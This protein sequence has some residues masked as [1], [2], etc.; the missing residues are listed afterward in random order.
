MVDIY[1]ALGLFSQ[2]KILFVDSPDVAPGLKQKVAAILEANGVASLD[3]KRL[4]DAS[5]YAD[6]NDL[7]HIIA[8]T[9]DFPEFAV[10]NY[11]ML[12]II[13]PQYVLVSYAE[14]RLVPIRAHSPDPRLFLKEVFL[15]CTTSIP[16][17]DV[18]A[19]YG[20]VRAVGGQFMDDLTKF[21]THL[22]TMDLNDD[23][24]LVAQA[25]NLEQVQ[26]GLP[27]PIQI[28]LPHWIDDCLKSMK[29]ID[30][31]PYVLPAA[32]TALLPK[33]EAP[34]P[35]ETPTIPSLYGKHVYLSPSLNLSPR[36][37]DTIILMIRSVGGETLSLG[38]I[39]L[40]LTDVLITNQRSSEDFRLAVQHNKTH[41]AILIANFQWLQRT[42]GTQNADLPTTSLV[43]YPEPYFRGAQPF[44][45][46]V[47]TVTNYTGDTRPYLASL[48]TMLG[49][50]F[51]KTLKQTN[52]HL[53]AYHGIQSKKFEAA[54]KW[55]VK[56]VNHLWI[57]DCFR[58]L[59]RLDEAGE[60]YHT[61]YKIASGEEIGSARVDLELVESFAMADSGT[62]E[63]VVKEPATPA[64]EIVIVSPP[65]TSRRA[66]L[67]AVEQLH[68]DMDDL[69]FYQKQTK[70]R[71]MPLLREEVEEK[72][73]QQ[74]MK[75]E[76]KRTRSDETVSVKKLKT[77]EH[78]V[79]NPESGKIESD[80]IESDKI[81]SDK[82]ESGKKGKKTTVLETTLEPKAKG[83]TVD[84]S[85]KSKAR[86]QKSATPEPSTPFDITLIAT[87]MDF[88]ITRQQQQQL[89]RIG[90]KVVKTV[91]HADVIVSPKILRTE[92]FLR[93]L[94][95]GLKYVLHPSFIEDV[96][97][98]YVDNDEPKVPFPIEKYSLDV[99]TP[100][101]VAEFLGDISLS[102]L[103][104]RARK[105]QES[106][107]LFHDVVL[108]FSKNLPGGANV[109][110]GVM[111]DHGCSTANCIKVATLK[112]L[113]HLKRAETTDLVAY[114]LCAATKKEDTKLVESFGRLME[115]EGTLGVVVQWNW[116]VL[117]IFHMELLPFSE[118]TI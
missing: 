58:Q 17:D 97:E 12:P 42:I 76:A 23:K 45:G 50:K 79:E 31:Q 62:F 16:R 44:Q 72:L 52:T 91:A 10:A 108:N 41:P 1:K 102:E 4:D 18:L 66:K 21:T 87:G 27:P 9:V 43:Y 96:I 88:E 117:S 107:G 7:T 101:A 99:K 40:D 53:V 20:A 36:E 35:S 14:E 68:S 110:S 83:K 6:L 57:E 98:Y 30:E 115:S 100:E 60:R 47:I 94:A 103:L 93:G 56:I 105:C 64:K 13:T 38:P 74:Q 26:N 39:P 82:I 73:Q 90:V 81:K 69:N 67:K 24:S 75:A 113:K 109:I 37:L 46:L 55:G 118:Y 80:K 70:S 71:K 89:A 77:N 61:E 63:E 92:K 34:G 85:V 48:I 15:S 51:T 95:N 84:E 2:A 106:G 59:R 112:D 33:V 111:G 19:I 22:V 65:S 116:V 25:Y 11:Q 49:G 78:A 3:F 114:V 29:R 28:V 104:Q 8:T 5:L 54:A 86:K 32:S